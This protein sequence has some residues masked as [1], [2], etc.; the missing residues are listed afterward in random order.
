ME[1]K[2]ITSSWPNSENLLFPSKAGTHIDPKSFEIR[3]K[4]VSKR[5][6]I[7]KVNPHALRH[8]LATCLVEDRMPMNIVQGILG[9]S[10]IETTRKYLHKNTNTEREAIASMTDR[11]EAT[12]QLN[13]AKKRGK[14]AGITMPDFSEREGKKK[15]PTEA[16]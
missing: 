14:F 1:S 8:I 5:C 3:L 9:H 12:P 16:G 2:L 11:L 10:S 7:K 6:E 15:R 4:A 13:G